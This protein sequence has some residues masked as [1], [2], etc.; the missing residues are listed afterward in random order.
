MPYQNEL[1]SLIDQLTTIA[2]KYN[3]ALG[4][5]GYIIRFTLGIWA[6]IR[7]LPKHKKSRPKANEP[8]NVA[9]QPAT[10]QLPA[11][12]RSPFANAPTTFD[13]KIKAWG[14]IQ[15]KVKTTLELTN[16]GSGGNAYNVRV[17]IPRID[18][19]NSL[20]DLPR[21]RSSS[22]EIETP[23]LPSE[24]TMTIYYT[25]SDGVHL[26]YDLEITGITPHNAMIVM[27]F[28]AIAR[29]SS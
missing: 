10:F 17:S 5:A 8:K 29:V 3:P 4:L 22:F 20:Q 6:I 25:N 27:S 23:S 11:Q 2:A 12:T 24:I 18:Y 1:I 15:G 14:G 21:N 16:T 9:P 26:R 19:E 13:A 7:Y 28:P